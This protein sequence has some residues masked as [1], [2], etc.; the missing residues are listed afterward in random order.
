MLLRPLVLL[1]QQ[2]DEQINHT[3]PEARYCCRVV[4]QPDDESIVRNLLLEQFQDKELVLTA[5]SSKIINIK[6][7]DNLAQVE[8][9]ADFISDGRND[10]VLEQF[11]NLLRSN[12]R[13]SAVKWEFS[14]DTD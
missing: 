11:I 2:I 6:D 13:I 14:E 7:I 10:F 4:C 3:K 5:L 1:F 8:I 12:V 9:L